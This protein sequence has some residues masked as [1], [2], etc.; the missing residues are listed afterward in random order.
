MAGNHKDG[1]SGLRTQNEAVQTTLNCFWQS[2]NNNCT[3]RNLVAGISED[4]PKL[5]YCLVK[6][7]QHNEIYITLG[8]E[9]D[10]ENYTQKRIRVVSLTPPSSSLV[11]CITKENRTSQ[12][13]YIIWCVIKIT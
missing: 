13:E 12:K 3:I 9:G 5:F 4:Q 7:T 11:A 1:T 2:L 6:T 8:G 10:K